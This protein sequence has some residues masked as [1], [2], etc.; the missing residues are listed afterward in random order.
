MRKVRWNIPGKGKSGGLRII[1]HWDQ[2]EVCPALFFLFVY[3]KSVQGDLTAK[4]IEKLVK[5]LEA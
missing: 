3:K 2:S 1:Y 5:E 4:Q